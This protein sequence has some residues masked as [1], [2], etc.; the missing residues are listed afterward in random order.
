[1]DE[2]LRQAAHMFFGMGIA[3]MIL[4]LEKPLAVLILASSLFVGFL[5]TDSLMKGYRLP[6]ITPL[7]ETLERKV[8]LPGKG[9]FFF[10]ASALF[11]ALL[12]PAPVAAAGVLSLA[13]LDG[14]ATVAGIRFGKH[15]IVNGKS[16]EGS[17]AGILANA[18]V[19]LLLL[20][21]VWAVMA[22]LLA[23][24]VELISPV[25]DNLTIPVTVC[26]LLTAL[27]LL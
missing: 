9:A 24:F 19:L 14:V 10:T 2:N 23:G 18:I 8:V 25:D 27:G 11:C 16:A 7:V 4:F 13:V 26:L 20:P 6:L 22:S 17:A 15:R 12:F 1:M 5:L 21:P 3:A